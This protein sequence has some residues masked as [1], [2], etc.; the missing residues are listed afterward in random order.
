M[1]RLRVCMAQLEKKKPLETWWD[2][3]TEANRQIGLTKQAPEHRFRAPASNALEL[4]S[5]IC[6]PSHRQTRSPRNRFTTRVCE[7][8]SSEQM[9]FLCLFKNKQ[10]PMTDAFVIQTI[11]RPSG[12]SSDQH[13]FPANERSWQP[14]ASRAPR[15]PGRPGPEFIV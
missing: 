2:F 7:F 1:L 3:P 13:L 14:R 9:M 8:I 11:Q 12:H 15:A 4:S 6:K 10:S 5:A